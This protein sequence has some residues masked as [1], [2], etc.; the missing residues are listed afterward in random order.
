MVARFLVDDMNQMGGSFVH[1]MRFLYFFAKMRWILRSAIGVNQ[2]NT[3]QL[4]NRR[5][6]SS[7]LLLLTVLFPR[8]G[9]LL[10]HKP[11][12]LPR[13]LRPTEAPGQE[14]YSRYRVDGEIPDRFEQESVIVY[15]YLL[16]VGC[17]KVLLQR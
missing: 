13:L 16:F 14:D 17:W 11:L 6:I 7:L 15:L 9:L 10:P 8:C 3:F 4:F 2:E 5:V 12:H 1:Q